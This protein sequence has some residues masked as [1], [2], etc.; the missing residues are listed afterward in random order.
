MHLSL[1]SFKQ[2]TKLI[3][4][5]FTLCAKEKLKEEKIALNTLYMFCWI[6]LFS[7]LGSKILILVVFD[8][9]CRFILNIWMLGIVK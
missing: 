6:Y 7:L 4:D 3:Q 2:V 5:K 1:L 8:F 9:K